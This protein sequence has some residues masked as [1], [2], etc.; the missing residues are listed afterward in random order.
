VALCFQRDSRKDQIIV[1]G[2][3][4]GTAGLLGWAAVRKVLEA[5]EGQLGFGAGLGSGSAGQLGGGGGGGRFAGLGRRGSGRREEDRRGS[6][7][8]VG[9]QRQDGDGT[10]AASGRPG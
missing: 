8:P 3:I 2:F 5:R 6:Y 4:L 1:W 9:E 7:L 10:G